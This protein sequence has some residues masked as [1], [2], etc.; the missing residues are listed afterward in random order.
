[1]CHMCRVGRGSRKV[2]RRHVPHVFLVC[3]AAPP[4]QM[5]THSHRSRRPSVDGPIPVSS[6]SLTVVEDGLG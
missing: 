4:S 6:G 5:V 1:M 2:G 3:V